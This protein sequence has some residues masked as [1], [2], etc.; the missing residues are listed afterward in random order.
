MKT[1]PIGSLWFGSVFV[2]MT[3]VSTT[4]GFSCSESGSISSGGAAG[5]SSSSTTSSGGG[6]AGENMGGNG[7][8]HVCD[9][10]GMTNLPQC[11]P[12]P[13]VCDAPCDGPVTCH[14]MLGADNVPCTCDAKGGPY[15]WKCS[16]PAEK[17]PPVPAGS[18]EDYPAGT[19]CPLYA[20]AE[21]M[22]YC[23][24]QCGVRAWGSCSF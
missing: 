18:C 11:P 5:A 16:A 20:G 21:G 10:A 24:E 13:P 4:G 3:M 2:V 14:C 8:G 1:H 12:E 17:C 9:D 15:L 6:T 19:I 7:G 23:I 22:C